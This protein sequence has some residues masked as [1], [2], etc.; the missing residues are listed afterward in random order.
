M[1]NYRKAADT[2]HL[3]KGLRKAGLAERRAVLDDI[4]Q[5]H[6]GLGLGQYAQVSPCHLLAN[7]RSSGHIQGRS[8]IPPA[9][10]IPLL[11][12]A[13]HPIGSA[14]PPASDVADTPAEGRS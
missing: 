14:L 13:F 2:E 3:L 9:S 5:W 6:E 11:M 1:H 4:S 10:D 12:S 8:G 7:K